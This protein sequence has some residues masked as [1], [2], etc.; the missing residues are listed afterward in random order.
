[1]HTQIL[2]QVIKVYKPIHSVVNAWDR[3]CTYFTNYISYVK[4]RF[5]WNLLRRLDG[6]FM[7]N[8]TNSAVLADNF[9][10]VHIAIMKTC[11]RVWHLQEKLAAACS[12]EVDHFLLVW[13]SAKIQV[14]IQQ[15]FYNFFIYNCFVWKFSMNSWNTFSVLF[16]SKLQY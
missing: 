8:S 7:S 1:M 13:Y 6:L 4:F 2:K 3:D 5:S 16:T 12:K 9:L 15:A 14:T 10:S 11:K